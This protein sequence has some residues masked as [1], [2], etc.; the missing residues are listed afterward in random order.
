MILIT[1]KDLPLESLFI[2]N[3]APCS[4]LQGILW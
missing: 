1:L 3:E 2:P 4:K